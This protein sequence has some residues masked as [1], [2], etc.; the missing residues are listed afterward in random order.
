V[1]HGDPIRAALCHWLGIPLDF[2]VRFEVAPG[3]V[4]IVNL[5]DDGVSVQGMNLL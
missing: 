1:S 3:S 4:S 5:F 2:M